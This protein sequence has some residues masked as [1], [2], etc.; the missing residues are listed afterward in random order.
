MACMTIK[1][2]LLLLITLFFI[3]GVSWAQYYRPRQTW[4]ELNSP[5]FRIVYKSGEDSLARASAR[6][7]ETQYPFTARLTGGRLSRFPVILNDYNDLSNGYV[8]PLLF[9]SEVEVPAIK[10]KSMSPRTGGWLETVLPHELVHA[11]N[12]NVMPFPGISWAFSILSPDYGRSMNSFAHSGFLEGIAVY[13]ESTVG[14]DGG[15]G[16]LSSFNAQFESNWLEEGSVRRWGLGTMLSPAGSSNP[17]S[18]HYIGGYTFSRWLAQQY[19]E[20]SIRDVIDFHSRWPI[21]GFGVSL[22]AQTGDNPMKMQRQFNDWYQDER[23]ARLDSSQT[24]FFTRVT[25]PFRGA[26]VRRPIWV[27]ENEILFHATAYNETAGFHVYH[28]DAGSI[29]KI[30][31]TSTIEDFVYTYNR[32]SNTL[33]FGTY[34]PHSIHDNRYTSRIH[35][36]SLTSNIESVLP[37]TDHMFAPVYHGNSVDALINDGES[38]AW[39]RITDSGGDTLLAPRPNTLI[40]LAPKPNSSITAVIANRNGYQG[41]WFVDDGEESSLFERSADIGFYNA[42]VIDIAWNSTGEKLILTVDDGQS[43]QLMEYDLGRTELKVIQLGLRSVMEASYSP[44]DTRIAFVYLEGDQYLPGIMELS[45]IKRVVISDS[46]WKDGSDAPLSRERLGSHLTNQSYSWEIKRYKSGLTWLKP[47]TISPFWSTESGLIANRFGIS[48]Q[49]TELLRRHTYQLDLSTSNNRLWYELTYIN[50]SFY[51]GFTIQFSSEPLNGIVRTSTP[52]GDVFDPIMIEDRQV[53][54]SIPFQWLLH[55]NVHTS[56]LVVRPE[57]QLRSIRAIDSKNG[58]ALGDFND[59]QTVRL[60]SAYYHRVER[61]TRDVQYRKGIIFYGD[62]RQ[63]LDTY[64][65][66]KSKGLRLGADTFLR[67]VPRSNQSLLIRSQV[68]TQAGSLFYSSENLHRNQFHDV[69]FPSSLNMVNLQLRY[70]IPLLY[71]DRGSLLIPWYVERAYIVLFSNTVAPVDK[72]LGFNLSERSRSSFG[73]ELRMVTGFPNFRIDI[74]L[75]IGFEPMRNKYSVYI[76]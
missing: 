25:L 11:Q 62:A 9:R 6:I 7:L 73:A 42:S 24:H 55:Q 54:F 46:L 64:L 2:T 29:K 58:S 17:R 61:A 72:E 4:S 23:Q 16:N 20:K 32:N 63:D 30:L 35:Q 68:L 27:N 57:L 34:H 21:L 14:V 53:R 71:P 40:Q 15:R 45:A 70:G 56:L 39:V 10:G 33:L 47:R 41:V 18:R 37:N 76:Q 38:T 3:N 59:I 31:K 60:Y 22:W 26:Q 13:H 49:S 19:G 66:N 50:S 5:H 74:G 75:G 36:F 65:T 69:P 12:M 28:L 1:S 43:V 44:D 67:F 52:T 48:L 8:S 51:P